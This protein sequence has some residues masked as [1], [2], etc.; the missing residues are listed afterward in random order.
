MSL[1]GKVT[2]VK[3]KTAIVS[4][5]PRTECK[6]CHACSGLAGE[7]GKAALR[8]IEA[9]KGD[10]QVEPGDEVLLDLNP[11][12]GS[13]A[14]LLVFGLP[15]A[16]FFAGLFLAPGIATHLG[17]ALTDLVRIISGFTCM[18]AAFGL[19]AI[20]SRSRHASRLSMKIIKKIDA[21]ELQNQ[22]AC[23]LRQPN[24]N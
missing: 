1:P 22:S 2:T 5:V 12:E 9:I 16:A 21:S 18:A 20:F 7:D 23:Q 3:E 6:G 13:I 24:S 4:V 10:F 19:L 14:A 8:E 11:G 15:M 17:I